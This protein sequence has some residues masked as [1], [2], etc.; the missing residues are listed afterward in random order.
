MKN[1]VRNMVD[2]ESERNTR[3]MNELREQVVRLQKSE[4][5]MKERD[6]Q[7]LME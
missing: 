6:G 3:A 5:E 4:I 1:E 7:R 2:E